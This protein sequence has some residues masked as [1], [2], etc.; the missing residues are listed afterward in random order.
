MY[1]NL[2]NIDSIVDVVFICMIDLIISGQ[3]V[4]YSNKLRTVREAL[5]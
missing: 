2:T 4:V 5:G 1:I 3:A